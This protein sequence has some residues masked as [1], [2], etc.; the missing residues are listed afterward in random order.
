M[1]CN[2]LCN[3]L[4]PPAPVMTISDLLFSFRI[5]DGEDFQ[6]YF[7]LGPLNISPLVN[8]VYV[9]QFLRY[10]CVIIKNATANTCRPTMTLR[11]AVLIPHLD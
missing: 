8:I 7:Y 11:G 6:Y 4:I 5:W 3:Q 1:L 10:L 9:Q 2:D